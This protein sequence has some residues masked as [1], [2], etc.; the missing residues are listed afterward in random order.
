VEEIRESKWGM[1]RNAENFGMNSIFFYTLTRRIKRYL[2]LRASLR[3]WN[4]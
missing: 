3:I 2:I 4:T 1:E